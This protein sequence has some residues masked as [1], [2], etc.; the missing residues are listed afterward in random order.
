[1][2]SP[3]AAL[4]TQRPDLA[5]FEEF[6][7]EMQKRGFIAQR[8][9][10]VVDVASQSG[11]FGKITIESL[12]Q[13]RQTERASGGGYNRT[14]WKFTKQTYA[15]EEHGI[16]EPVDQR[17]AAAYAE[18]FDAELMASKRAGEVVLRNQEQ[19]AASLVF[20]ATT[21]TGASLT[22][23]ITHE[24]DD[25]ANAV[26]LTDVEAAVQKVYDNTGIWPNALVI[27]RKVFRNLRMCASI[28]AQFKSQ[29]FVDVRASKITEQ[30]L[31]TIFDL[32]H[33][34][35]AGSS[36][37]S[38]NEGQSASIS[39]I[40]SGEYAMVC[41]VAETQD[42]KEPCIGR[43]FHWGEDGSEIMG[44]VEQYYEEQSR[45]DIYRMRHDVDEVI[46]YP[47]MGHMLSNITT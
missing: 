19:R 36:K 22:T 28:L 15:T 23:G 13:N 9:L 11:S 7:L 12:L 38:A 10:P 44:H 17:E 24:W 41:R 35:V 32:D 16:E 27:N 18:Y 40:W 8:V 30:M 14:N 26:P 33:I 37:N 39:P 45:S 25:Y 20:N 1:M 21:W 43:I 2:P 34:I 5:T 4:A 47:E 46:L 3:S 31:A 42:M 29:G 6:D